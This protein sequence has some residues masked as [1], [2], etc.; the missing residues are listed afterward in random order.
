MNERLLQYIW[1]FQYYNQSEL[2]TTQGEPVQILFAGT[3]NTNQGPDFSNAKIKINDTLWVGNI[4]IHIRASDWQRHDHDAGNDYKNVILHVVWDNDVPENGLPVLELKN[5]I[6]RFLLSKYEEWMNA[7]AFIAC[8]NS[9]AGIH[10]LVWNAWKERLLA[11]R[12]MRK[13]K[14]IDN[15]L[16][17]NKYHWEETFWW[18]L[19][20]NFGVKVNADAFEAIAKSIPV[21]IIAKHKSQIHQLEALLFGQAGLLEQDFTEEYPRLLQREYAF[22]K[23]KHTLQPVHH[24][25]HFLRM[26]PANFPSV[27]LAQLAMLLHQ[28]VHLFSKIK[29]AVSVKEVYQFFTTPAN[30]YWHYHYR[31]DECT[32]YKPKKI[33]ASM[34]DNIVINT[35]V[36]F[37]FAWGHYHN[38]SRYKEKALR[39]LEET[40]A[41]KNTIT[42]GFAAL[43]I[44]NKTAYDS[45][46]LI[47]LKN[48]YCNHKRCLEC[49][50]G[51]ALFRN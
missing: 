3:Y 44:E 31:F 30:D 22:L 38:D 17:Q 28:S 15:S 24:S 11:E 19:A 25:L 16:R 10:A 21:T 49:S 14:L 4:E 7:A 12:L 45:Q 35:V 41:E 42:E 50:V 32:D 2:R 51:N 47:E 34:T 29:E 43:S 46:S 48:E 23:T 37:L 8:D 9:I 36:P 1:Q 6:S 5:R 33:G 13:A 20:R 18:F 26:R 39:W 27:R 40:R